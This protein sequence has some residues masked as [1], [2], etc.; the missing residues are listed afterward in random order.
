MVTGERRGGAAAL[1]MFRGLGPSRGPR[2]LTTSAGQRRRLE[3]LAPGRTV[4]PDDDR[5][6]PVAVA[7]VRLLL[8]LGLRIGRRWTVPL[9]ALVERAVRRIRPRRRDVQQHGGVDLGL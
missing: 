4:V 5:R 7:A 3:E 2:G 1:R 8:P 9:D 6:V